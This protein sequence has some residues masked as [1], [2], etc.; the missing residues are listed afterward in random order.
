MAGGTWEKQDKVRPGAYINIATNGTISPVGPVKGIVALP[1]ELDFGPE[2]KVVKIQSEDDLTAWGYDLT[3]PQLLLIK[4]ALKRA[5][6][7]LAYRV[8]SG[9]K[10][11]ITAGTSI[12]IT[13]NSSGI[14]GNDIQ[15]TAK[16]SV[17]QSGF[18]E[19][20]T[21]LAGR[22][23]DQQT[24]K[25]VTDLKANQL[26]SFTGEGAVTTFSVELAGGTTSVA[27]GQDYAD[28]FKE[29]QL[30][31]FNTLALPVKDE[32]IKATGVAFMKRLREEEGKKSQIVVA[33]YSADH[34]SVIN[35]KNGVILAN[36]TT[37]SAE[38]ATAWVAGATAGAGVAQS[39]TYTK[40]EEA[41]TVTQRFLNSEII[42]ALQNGEFIFT[43]KRGEVVVEQDINSLHSFTPEKEALFA[44]NRVLRILDD[45]ANNTKQTFED[46]FLGKTTTDQDGLELFKANRIAYFDALQAAGAITNF[47]AEDIT[48]APGEI[49]D[50][51]VLNVAVQPVD[52][53]EK[54]YVTV[55]VV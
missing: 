47:K 38:Q 10:A 44:K 30:F 12:A 21:F 23:I 18:Y 43:E 40:Y 51:I 4:E 26:V 6:L 22:K 45:I 32:T 36:G 16:A 17:D 55:Q 46:I 9:G 3:N 41:V 50:A 35:V 52:A 53:M 42:A 33:G 28:F 54:L 15:I 27:T 39:L 48:V 11:T 31:D 24:V 25:A 14:R 37:L 49:R 20:T 1:L 8:N 29:I 7:V 13:A 19:V 5:Q 2:K 34:E